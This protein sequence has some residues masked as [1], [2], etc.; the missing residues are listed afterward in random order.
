MKGLID[1]YSCMIKNLKTNLI[2]MNFFFT[3]FANL[4]EDLGKI[5][6]DIN[7][8]LTPQELSKVNMKMVLE[9]M[10]ELGK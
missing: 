3:H 1:F 6:R 5:L 4:D 7:K 9:Y 10:E 2:S 8:D